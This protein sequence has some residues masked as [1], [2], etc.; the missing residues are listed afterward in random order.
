MLRAAVTAGALNLALALPG[1]DAA[2]KR[3][4]AFHNGEEEEATKPKPTKK[5]ERILNTQPGYQWEDHGGYCGSWSIQRAVMAKGAWISQQQ[6][7]DHTVPGGG[8]DNEIL[9]T[10][11]ELALTNLKLTFEGFD[12]KNLPTPQ[13]DSGRKWMK[14]QLVA[15]N[16]LVQMIMLPGGS[17]PVYP[18]LPYGTYSHIEPIVGILSDKPLTD[19]DFYDDDYIVHYNDAGEKPLYRSMSSLPGK[20]GFLGLAACPDNDGL[21]GSQMCLNPDHVFSW[22]IKGFQDSKEG[23][24][25]SLTVD[26]WKEE[27]D[28]RTGDSPTQMTGTLTMEG[29]E[30]GQAYA[31]YRWNSIESAFDYSQPASVYR[32]SATNVT[33]VYQD[34][35]TF[36]SDGTIYYRCIADAGVV[37]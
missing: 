29:L 24:P 23:L 18:N 19:E 37:V 20:M 17:Y 21:F 26:G 36:S 33:E 14:Q 30:A 32:F 13:L 2:A 12:Y 31:L 9:A 35:K 4:A 3:I 10:N 11:I 1:D 22:A 8:N 28:T 25:V 15:G 5:Y 7:R 6:V 27:P 34:P 16:A